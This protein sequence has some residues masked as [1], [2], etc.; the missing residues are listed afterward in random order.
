[1]FLSLETMEGMLDFGIFE[2]RH[3]SLKFHVSTTQW[4]SHFQGKQSEK[5]HHSDGPRFRCL[6]VVQP[7]GV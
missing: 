7:V 2:I 1:M 4:Q 6:V 3:L 5:K